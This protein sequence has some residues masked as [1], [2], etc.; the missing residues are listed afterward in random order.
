MWGA[1]GYETQR[2][3]SNCGGR[4]EDWKRKNWKGREVCS[5]GL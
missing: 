4:E 1:A 3:L 2:R 5:L